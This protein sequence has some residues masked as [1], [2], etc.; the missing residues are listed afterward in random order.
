[1]GRA[2]TATIVPS[3]ALFRSLRELHQEG[4]DLR[5]IV[6][7]DSP[8]HA[9]EPVLVEDGLGGGAEAILHEHGDRKS[10]RL[11]SSHV[12]KSY[13]VFWM[14]KTNHI[15]VVSTRLITHY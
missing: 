8:E 14:R 5:P 9:S 2:A 6:G 11:H 4:F 15:H 10:T 3:T 1:M 12:K 7:H 13:A